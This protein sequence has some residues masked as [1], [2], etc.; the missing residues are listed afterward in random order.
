MKTDGAGHGVSIGFRFI[1]HLMIKGADYSYLL[2]LMRQWSDH[3]RLYISFYF[4]FWS[5]Q[6][7][8]FAAHVG[9]DNTVNGCLIH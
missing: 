9:R 2:L 8:S 5:V 4:L 7:F 6:M 3:D 1:K